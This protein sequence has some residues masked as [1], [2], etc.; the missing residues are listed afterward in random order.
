LKQ[1]ILNSNIIIILPLETYL[2]IF[3]ICFLLFHFYTGSAYYLHLTHF[4]IYRNYIYFANAT[5]FSILRYNQLSSSR[6]FI[7]F[8]SIIKDFFL[9]H[10]EFILHFCHHLKN[11]NCLI[12]F[13]WFITFYFSFSFYFYFFFSFFFLS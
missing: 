3:F 1:P 8:R 12:Y 4:W 13:H 10:R 2:L 9:A 11:L 6:Q 7:N 5:S